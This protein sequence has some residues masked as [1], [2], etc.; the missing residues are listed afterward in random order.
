MPHT[1]RPEDGLRRERR[2]FPCILRCLREDAVGVSVGK[3]EL[4]SLR[5]GNAKGQLARL[6]FNIEGNACRDG[7][8]LLLEAKRKEGSIRTKIAVPFDAKIAL[9]DVERR[10]AV[11]LLDRTALHPRRNNL[12]PERIPAEITHNMHIQCCSMKHN[13]QHAK[14]HRHIIGDDIAVCIRR[15]GIH[16]GAEH[17]DPLIDR[18]DSL[19]QIIDPIQ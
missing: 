18:R 12:A 8:V 11:Q 6:R 14:P 5:Y 2:H 7:P 10:T 3:A 15:N 17:L 16:K 19:K 4:G 13:A 1:G 9:I